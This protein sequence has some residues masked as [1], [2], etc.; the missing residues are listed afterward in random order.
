MGVNRL[1]KRGKPKIEVRK[2][3]PD[4][5]TFRRYYSNVTLA[6]KVSARV[7]ESIVMG[8]WQEFREE[9]SQGKGAKV[10]SRSVNSPRFTLM[11]IAGI[12]TGGLILRCKSWCPSMQFWEI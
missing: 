3:W 7:E 8:T 6:K 1:I 2:R 4:G 5:T 11:T 12:T 10:I 9:L